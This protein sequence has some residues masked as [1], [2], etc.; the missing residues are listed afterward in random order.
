MFNF[1]ILYFFLNKN[2]FNYTSRSSRFDE[3]YLYNDK[4]VIKLIN[5]NSLDERFHLSMHTSLI[6]TYG[7]T[8]AFV[9]HKSHKSVEIMRVKN[10][11][12]THVHMRVKRGL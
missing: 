2:N 10:Q 11:L 7:I 4:N 5:I 6:E 3:E 8:L 12:Q 9:H 1:K